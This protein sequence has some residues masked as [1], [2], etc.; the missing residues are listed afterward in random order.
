MLA[1]AKRLLRDESG[2]ALMIG[3]AFMPLLLGAAGLAVDT[4]QLGVW[5]REL[6]RAADS[7][8]VAGAYSLAQGGT[9]AEAVGRDLEQN[10]FP[11]LSGEEVVQVGARAGFNQAVHVEL[12]AERALPFMSLFVDDAPVIRANATAALVDDGV[13][14]VLSLYDGPDAGIDVN[15]NANVNLGCGMATNSRAPQAIT[16]GG[17]S[18][19]TS[20]PLM[21]VGGLVGS[22]NNFA[23]GTI[24][25]P[26]SAEQRDP[27]AYLADPPAQSGCVD[28]DIGEGDATELSPGCYS[29]MTIKGSVTLNP[30]T[31]YVT[32]DIDF[33]AKA[34][35]IGEGV[36]FVMTGPGGAAGDL[37][38]NAQA[39]LNLTAPDDGPYRDVLF[40]R[41]RRADNIEIKINGGADA[42]LSG[43]F[44]FP[45]SDITFA[46]HAGLQVRCFQMVGQILKFRGTSDLI[47]TCADRPEL[48]GFSLNFVRLVG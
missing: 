21:S 34:D 39:T 32:G 24:L 23:D 22:S 37:K 26:H 1:F 17:S 47:N 48:P 11:E 28:A 14:C 15:G 2:N 27:F 4:I 20:S 18:L 45:T 31:Y 35:V 38:W 29:S 7:G 9:P 44:Y 6:Q 43:A 8:A 3:A 46:G 16:A 12:T 41:D 36:T 25:Q 42:I 19:V 30:G 10:S 5:K 13:F 40:Y 33:G